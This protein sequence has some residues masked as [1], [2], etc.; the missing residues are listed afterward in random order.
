MGIYLPGRYDSQIKPNYN[1]SVLKGVLTNLSEEELLSEI[2]KSYENIA[3]IYRLKSKDNKP[4]HAV[5]ITLKLN[6]NWSMQLKMAFF[7]NQ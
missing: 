3:S 7:Y 2:E 1:T 4:L 5:K 6:N